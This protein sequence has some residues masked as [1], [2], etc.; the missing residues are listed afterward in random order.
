MNEISEQ[1]LEE[2]EDTILTLKDPRDIINN[3]LNNRL[4]DLDVSEENVTRSIKDIELFMDALMRNEVELDHF[5]MLEIALFFC[6]IR[7]YQPPEVSSHER[8]PDLDRPEKSKKMFVQR[9]ILGHFYIVLKYI[10]RLWV[11]DRKDLISSKLASWPLVV[12]HAIRGALYFKSVLISNE[13]GLKK[14]KTPKIY[15]ETEDYR[16]FKKAFYLRHQQEIL[17]FEHGPD[18]GSRIKPI[19]ARLGAPGETPPRNRRPPTN[20]PEKALVFRSREDMLHFLRMRSILSV[21]KKSFVT[22]EV[23]ENLAPGFDAVMLEDDEAAFEG[24]PRARMMQ[25][26]CRVRDYFPDVKP[27]DT[28]D[29]AEAIRQLDWFV[30]MLA[31]HVASFALDDDPGAVLGVLAEWPPGMQHLARVAIFFFYNLVIDARGDFRFVNISANPTPL[32]SYT[33]GSNRSVQF[34]LERVEQILR[35]ENVLPGSLTKSSGVRARIS[36]RA[37]QQAPVSSLALPSHLFY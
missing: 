22:A 1:V 13:G 21:E 19:R 32:K 28:V 16:A 6:K 15:Y 29:T 30:E 26:M 31:P 36:A 10:F 25:M 17:H 33:F 14:I 7:G 11:E 4:S 9:E 24:H 23:V 2:V 8:Q 5:D 3:F 37:P 20:D 18:R 27:A 34:Y 35:L 12:T